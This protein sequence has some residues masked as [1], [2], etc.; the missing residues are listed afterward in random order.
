MTKEK[1]IQVI[2]P[3]GQRSLEECQDLDPI[4]VERR[5]DILKEEIRVLEN[6]VKFH[7]T[8]HIKTTISIMYFPSYSFG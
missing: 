2:N 1:T 5:L 8:G 7:D 3:E 4:L 6:R